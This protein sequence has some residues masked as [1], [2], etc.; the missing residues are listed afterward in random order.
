MGFFNSLPVPESSKVIPAH[1]WFASAYQWYFTLMASPV[2]VSPKPLTWLCA[3]IL[4]VFTVLF[5]SSIFI[6]SNFICSGKKQPDVIKGDHFLMAWYWWR[7]ASTKKC[8]FCWTSIPGQAPGWGEGWTSSWWWSSVWS[9]CPQERIWK[10]SS[11]SSK[12]FHALA[13]LLLQPLAI[14]REHSK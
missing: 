9:T 12:E 5:T 10:L 6:L 2:S 4:W 3:E 7:L 1:P 11:L 8:K 13:I 14:L